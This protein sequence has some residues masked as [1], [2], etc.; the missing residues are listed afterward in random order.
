[1]RFGVLVLLVLTIWS[2]SNSSVYEQNFDVDEKG[3]SYKDPL[4][5]EFKIDDS[6]QNYNLFINLK[7]NKS[8]SYRNVFFFVDIQ[9]PQEKVLRDTIEL[10][11]ASSTGKWLGEMSGDYVEQKLVFR[12]NI[13]FPIEGDYRI[14]IQ[15]A[16]RDTF[17]QKISMV[18]MELKEYTEPNK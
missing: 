12:L 14:K 11:L 3:W 6:K 18:G 7:F 9:D 5:F 2:C 1:M 10:P 15:Q 4:N 8:Y 16:M 17:L 13:S